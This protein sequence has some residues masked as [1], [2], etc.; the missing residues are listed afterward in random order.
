MAQVAECLSD[1]YKAKFKTSVLQT[2]KKCI[3]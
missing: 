2:N 3:F 1:K